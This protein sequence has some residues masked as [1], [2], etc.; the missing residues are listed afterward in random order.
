MTQ[1]VLSSAPDEGGF[2]PNNTTEGRHT[3]GRLA[4]MTNDLLDV[5]EQGRRLTE[6]GGDEAP[7]WL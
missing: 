7:C 5:E 1:K 3:L 6:L 2:D 4:L